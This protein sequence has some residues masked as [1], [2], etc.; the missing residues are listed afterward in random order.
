MF[1]TWAASSTHETS[2]LLNS[3]N[4]CSFWKLTRLHFRY[5]EKGNYFFIQ[6]SWRKKIYGIAK[7]CRISRPVYPSDRPGTGSSRDAPVPRWHGCR[8]P[9][10]WCP[11]GP[12]TGR[13]TQPWH[14]RKLT[15]LV[16]LNTIKIVYLYLSLVLQQALV[17][18]VK[19]ER[20]EERVLRL[21]VGEQCLG[22]VEERHLALATDLGR[23]Y[24]LGL[25]GEEN[26]PLV[27][28]HTS[29]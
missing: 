10:W 26:L 2:L 20:V 13:R 14:I 7:P 19:D 11:A 29:V 24:R 25:F 5:P 27:N 4:L 1:Q 28:L 9:A 17:G 15:D 16:N 8:P 6:S 12:R 3:L 23:G 21:D 18:S 22:L